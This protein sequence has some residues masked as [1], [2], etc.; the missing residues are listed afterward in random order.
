MRLAAACAPYCL[1][2]ARVSFQAG[3]SFS[4]SGRPGAARGRNHTPC[5]GGRPDSAVRPLC[6]FYPGLSGPRARAG[7][8][9]S[10]QAQSGC[11]WRFA[12]RFDP[13]TRSCASALRAHAGGQTQPAGRSGCFRRALAG[14]KPR[15]SRT[16]AS[17]LPGSWPRKNQALCHCG[18]LAA[19]GR[20]CFAVPFCHR[21]AFAAAGQRAR[22]VCTGA[23]PATSFRVTGRAGFAHGS[24]LSTACHAGFWCGMRASKENLCTNVIPLKWKAQACV[25]RP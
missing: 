16:G 14:S 3:Q 12:A 9:I 19:A 5:A 4:V 11:L 23:I 6:G 22:M 7:Y 13:A 25:S 1:M 18:R 8:G 17:G 20:C 2:P 15:F 21:V 10:A 24:V